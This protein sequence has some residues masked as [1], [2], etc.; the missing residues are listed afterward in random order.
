[1][2]LT[3]NHAHARERLINLAPFDGECE[4]STKYLKLSI[5]A[6]YSQAGVL[7]ATEIP[8]YFFGGNASSRAFAS[9]LYSS[10]R[11]IPFS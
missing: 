10:R 6:G 4:H 11:A 9:R 2:R 3:G 5:D 8:G 1:V 7:P